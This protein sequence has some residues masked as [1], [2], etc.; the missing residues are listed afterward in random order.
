MMKVHLNIRKIPTY[1][2]QF[3]VLTLIKR[4]CQMKYTLISITKTYNTSMLKYS[5]HNIVL[6]GLGGLKW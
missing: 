5:E 1:V 4:F 3:L 6:S 2:A